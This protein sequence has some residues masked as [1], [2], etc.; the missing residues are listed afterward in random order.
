MKKTILFIFFVITNL[1]FSQDTLIDSAQIKNDPIFSQSDL[2]MEF[3][4]TI[5]PY[6]PLLPPNTYTEVPSF[7]KATPRDISEVASLV[8]DS[9]I[10]RISKKDAGELEILS[11]DAELF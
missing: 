11:Q 1:I 4:N 5:D 9:R 2:E 8:R 6:N 3:K 10:S 7:A